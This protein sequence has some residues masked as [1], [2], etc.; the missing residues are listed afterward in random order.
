MGNLNL[1]HTKPLVF[2]KVQTTGLSLSKDRIVEMS[3]T[4]VDN[5]T[6]EKTTGTRLINPEMP[7]SQEATNIHGITDE[8]V[9]SKPKFKDI[10]ESVSKFLEG[11]DFVGFNISKFDLRILSEEF[12]RAGIEFLAHNRN[13]IDLAT[14][15][16]SMEPRD[17]NAA[18]KFYCNSQL[19][20]KPGSEQTT[21]M[22]FDILNGMISKYN[23]IEHVNQNN[24][25]VKIEATA[26]SLSSAFCKNKKHLDIGGLIVM[27]EQ[28]RPVFNPAVKLKYAGK[29]VAESMIGDPGY[30]DWYVNASDFPADTKTIIKK[31]VEKAKTAT[32]VK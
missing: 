27:N 3:F 1:A 20:K 6:G 15:Y 11:C 8:M 21:E 13:I 5:V 16:H 32:T 29:L 14:I 23:G 4:K 31:I 17:L 9:K 25:N 18:Y 22:Y 7:I 24:E 28:Q 12:N 10:A 2:I 30:Y 19:E 26:E